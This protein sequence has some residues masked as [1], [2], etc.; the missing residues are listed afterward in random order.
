[1]MSNLTNGGRAWGGGGMA[2]RM[3]SSSYARFRTPGR[4]VIVVSEAD[5]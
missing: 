1:M 4:G 5:G 3:R 2:S